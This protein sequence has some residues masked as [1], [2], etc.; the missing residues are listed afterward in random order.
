MD[1]NSIIEFAARIQYAVALARSRTF[2]CFTDALDRSVEPHAITVAGLG[3]F[4]EGVRRIG[5]T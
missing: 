5:M 2:L 4:D 3:M 1:A